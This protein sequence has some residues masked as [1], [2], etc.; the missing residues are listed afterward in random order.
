MVAVHCGHVLGWSM[1]VL[2]WAWMLILILVHVLTSFEYGLSS[3]YFYFNGWLFLW[4]PISL[5]FDLVIGRFELLHV[6][7]LGD[8]PVV[9]FP[10]VVS[11]TINT[12]LQNLMWNWTLDLGGAVA[13]FAIS[14]CSW[15]ILL[16]SIT[17]GRWDQQGLHL[18]STR[19]PILQVI[20]I[21]PG[22]F[23]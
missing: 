8:F 13:S 20:P 6:V 21:S 23:L 5:L 10:V 15:N 7:A 11:G 9:G 1:Q 18:Q 4:L 16:A 22:E 3:S 12:V 2:Y 14:T 17:V 19:L